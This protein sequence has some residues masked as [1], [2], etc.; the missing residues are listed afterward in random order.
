MRR[1]EKA[2]MRKCG[3]KRDSHKKHIRH[4]IGDGAALESKVEIQRFFT[5]RSSRR[6]VP[7]SREDY[8]VTGGKT[9][10]EFTAETQRSRRWR[11]NRG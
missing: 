7:Q 11:K 3:L 2:S 6:P 4:K 5:G 1:C 9:G 8:G 10:E